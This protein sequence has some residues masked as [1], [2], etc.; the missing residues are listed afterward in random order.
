MDLKT[1]KESADSSDWRKSA[2]F[3]FSLVQSMRFKGMLREAEHLETHFRCV[4]IPRYMKSVF[5]F[6]IEE[7]RYF[8]MYLV[9]NTM[10]DDGSVVH[11]GACLENM[12]LIYHILKLECPS[13]VS[14]CPT[15]KDLRVMKWIFWTWKLNIRN[16]S[17]VRDSK[18]I[19]LFTGQ[20]VAFV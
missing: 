5:P 13:L 6:T 10:R 18:L 11:F 15:E 7:N 14:P 12:R 20:S 16:P 3:Y 9:N 4:S 17:A 1:I 19:K 2:D 8:L